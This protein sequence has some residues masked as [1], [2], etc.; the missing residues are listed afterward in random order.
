MFPAIREIGAG[1][2]ARQ[3]MVTT[4]NKWFNKKDSEQAFSVIQG[5]TPL[6]SARGDLGEGTE[7]QGGGGRPR[8]LVTD[9]SFTEIRRAPFRCK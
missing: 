3:R 6:W 4:N 1:T 7:D 2:R 5:Q 9:A 8:V